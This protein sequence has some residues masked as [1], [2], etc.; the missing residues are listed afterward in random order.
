MLL[1]PALVVADIDYLALALAL[2]PPLIAA[3]PALVAPVPYFCAARLPLPQLAAHLLT[4]T[5]DLSPLL[6]DAALLS[7]KAGDCLD[8]LCTDAVPPSLDTPLPA[9]RRSRVLTVARVFSCQNSKLVLLCKISYPS[10]PGWRQEPTLVVAKL[11][12]SADAWREHDNE[13]AVL[14]VVGAS[15]WHAMFPRLLGIG[16]FSGRRPLLLMSYIP[17]PSL[18]DILRGPAGAPGVYNVGDKAVFHNDGALRQGLECAVRAL[19]GMGLKHDDLKG[20]NV[21]YR[22]GT[23]D[24]VVSPLGRGEGGGGGDTGTRGRVWLVDLESVAGLLRG[25]ALPGE[26]ETAGDEREVQE[27]LT[28]FWKYELCCADGGCRPGG[29]GMAVE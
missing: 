23:G 8:W 12:L 10:A 24:F 5:V 9:P 20:A 18:T 27:I 14:R 11:R 1:K 15:R 26:T 22:V 21:V 2:I 29:G 16:Q 17:Y 13:L 6:L 25:K 7:L 19:R 28:D 4:A 3:P